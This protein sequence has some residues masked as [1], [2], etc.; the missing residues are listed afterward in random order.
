M[1]LSD[2]SALLVTKAC[3]A[4]LALHRTAN[5]A[6]RAPLRVLDLRTAS[7]YLLHAL[8]WWLWA[9]GVLTIGVGVDHWVIMSANAKRVMSSLLAASGIRGGLSSQSRL[10]PLHS[11][12][13]ITA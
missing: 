5:R 10:P 6:R 1:R 12:W 4:A 2:V 13:A 7:D 11:R 3:V 8:L 9:A